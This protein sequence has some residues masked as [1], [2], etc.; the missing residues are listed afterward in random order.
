MT[1]LAPLLARLAASEE[2]FRS[3][4]EAASALN[5]PNIVGI[6]D[7]FESDTIYLVFEYVDG[8]SL[9]RR[10]G[11]AGKLDLAETDPVRARAAA[12]EM[13]RKLL[14]NTVIESFKVSVDG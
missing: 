14:A 7:I 10:L 6:Y 12:E 11:S 9:D 4:L 5:H 2:R 8:E 13:A 1:A 3:E